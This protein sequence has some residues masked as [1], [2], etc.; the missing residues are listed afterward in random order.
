[1]IAM[2][3]QPAP[4]PSSATCAES[5]LASDA[6]RREVARLLAL[7]ALRALWANMAPHVAEDAAEAP[8]A[9]APR[10]RKALALSGGV[11]PACGPARAP[12]PAGPPL[13]DATTETRP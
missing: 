11:E 13:A 3:S 5:T 10:S 2:A 7:G 12:A 9:A 6:Q 8:A 1:V 4:T